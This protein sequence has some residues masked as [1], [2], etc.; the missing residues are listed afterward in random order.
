MI[1]LP[2]CEEKG[3]SSQMDHYADVKAIIM[4][5]DIHNEDGGILC[6][7]GAWLAL[8]H[9]DWIRIQ[10]VSSG[11]C[12]VH[13]RQVKEFSHN[14]S[15]GPMYR[16]P[17]Y[18]L[19]EFSSTERE[20]VDYFWKRPSAFM[21]VT[22][23]HSN[24]PG[25]S[26]LE[27]A[28]ER[29]L[30][31]SDDSF[32]CSAS[33]WSKVPLDTEQLKHKAVY[34]FYRTLELS[35]VILV[36]KSDSVEALLS[37]IGRLYTLPEA[38]DVYSYC[39]IGTGELSGAEGL[40]VGDDCVPL[41]S[42]RF[43]VR[44]AQACRAQIP[45]LQSQVSSQG[46]TA[47]F[48]TGMEDINL[49]AYNNNSQQLCKL[50][51]SILFMGN[52]FWQAFE[53]STTR[54]GIQESCL[55]IWSSGAGV[56]DLKRKLFSAYQQLE[57]AFG[58]LSES[59][60][61]D[62]DWGRPLGELINLLGRISQDCVLWQISYILLN[63][64]QGL[65]RRVEEWTPA[66]T[67]LDEHNDR[68]IM[69]MVGGIDRLMEH[70]IRMEGELVHHPETRPILFDIPINLLEFYLLFLDQC[71]KYLQSREGSDLRR[72]FQLLLIPNLCQQIS[73]H[74]HLNFEDS[75]DHL[76]YVE[77]PLGL[78]YN[79]LHVVCVLVHEAAH[80]SG[81]GARNRSIRFHDLAVCVAF[82]IADELG[83]GDSDAVIRQLKTWVENLYPA[84]KQAYMRDIIDCL[85]KTANE[86]CQS[87]VKIEEL[88]TLYEHS[89]MAVAP[90]ATRLQWLSQH[91]AEYRRCKGAS[92]RNQLDKLLWEIEYLFKET[93]ADLAMLT[94][95]GLSA[96][97]Y[98]NMLE[99]SNSSQFTED[100][101]SYACKIER[102]ALVLCAID[103]NS[104]LGLSDC[105]TSQHPLAGDIQQYCRV[106]LDDNVDPTLL[107]SKEGLCGYH[108]L[109]VAGSILHYL[110]TCYESI[111]NY[112][113]KGENTQAKEKIQQIFRKY[114]V[115]QRFASIDFFCTIE[116]Y[117]PE[118]IDRMYS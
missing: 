102:A 44:N 67:I 112:D 54:L 42:T 29:Q 11:E 23:I 45:L 108:S 91:A 58:R 32:K 69:R 12:G 5:K 30:Q 86:I 41:I 26:C 53:N 57:I 43:D 37:C 1:G 35:D 55:P 60:T 111:Q 71:T 117:R 59:I 20:L 52:D 87:D 50:F 46:A 19:R 99:R 70:I 61:R 27:A 21:T 103:P 89:K 36:A 83:M 16:Q 10:T 8:G 90:R 74:D 18:I 13:L 2:L 40:A 77:I 73:T 100:V 47:F 113:S 79:P 6:P 65:I 96:E 49:I 31:R 97:D 85:L 63:G 17:L 72:N 25:Q 114:A 38:G 82:I 118:I 33:P 4:E 104:L 9:M 80:H 64:I 92:M 62:K 88:W 101:I 24:G 75:Q 7:S 68:E 78:L 34:I 95:L 115:E 48:I 109:E 56:P 39:C 14:L 110:K 15:T 116:E 84:D 22:R 66:T 94:L 81:E 51:Q 93:Y 105:V 98:I 76:L 107:P 3:M 106:L 28:I